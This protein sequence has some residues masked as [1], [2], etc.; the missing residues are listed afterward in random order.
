MGSRKWI[1]GTGCAEDRDPQKQRCRRR[2]LC[3]VRHDDQQSFLKKEKG[4][5]VRVETLVREALLDKTSQEL[6]DLLLDSDLWSRSGDNDLQNLIPPCLKNGKARVASQSQKVLTRKR[7]SATTKELD[8]VGVKWKPVARGEAEEWPLRLAILRGWRAIAQRK[9]SFNLS[10]SVGEAAMPQMMAWI[11]FGN[12]V[13]RG[14]A[15][16]GLQLPD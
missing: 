7:G 8:V 4:S 9:S 11:S 14:K 2:V 13:K 12:S 5:N 16:A 6:N 3:F 1:V 15:S 10:G